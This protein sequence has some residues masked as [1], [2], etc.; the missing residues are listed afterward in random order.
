MISW[1]TK[2][3]LIILAIVIVIFTIF[4]VVMQIRSCQKDEQIE[5][6][7]MQNLEQ[8]GYAVEKVDENTSFIKTI[9]TGKS[10]SKDDLADEIAKQ[11]KKNKLDVVYDAQVK[12]NMRIEKK[13]KGRTTTTEIVTHNKETEK[14]VTDPALQ[15][16]C[17]TCLAAVKVK[18]PFDVIQP[19]FHVKGY[20]LSGSAL[21]EPGDYE[22]DIT[23]AKQLMFEVTLTQDKKGN[24]NTLI[25]SEDFESEAI[26]SKISVKAFKQK[27][28]QKFSFPVNIMIS[29][30]LHLS[31]ST[32]I[33]YKFHKNVSAGILGGLLFLNTPENQYNWQLGAGV[34]IHTE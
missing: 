1:K 16:Q 26:K 28:Y 21:G 5:A 33:Y 7:M 29:K 6:L 23:L 3:F 20:T 9:K 34:I 17:N 25:Y 30:Q 18:V 19:P 15:E 12:A 24:W 13:L 11:I 14:I 27:W 8:T 31:L 4:G 32:G 10:I 2:L 22:L